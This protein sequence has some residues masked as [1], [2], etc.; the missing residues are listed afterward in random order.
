MY[1]VY[2]MT[3]PKPLDCGPTCLLMLL[4]YYGI[5]DIPLE[6]LNEECGINILG[7]SMGDLKRVGDAHGLEMH[8]YQTD[9]DGVI[10]ADRPSIC[11]WKYDHFVICCGLDDDGKVVICNPDKGRYRM[12]QGLFKTFYSGKALFNGVPEDI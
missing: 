6:T 12:S 5:H 7:C 3:S 8:A 11:W 9:I 1:D 10:K 2:P 4:N